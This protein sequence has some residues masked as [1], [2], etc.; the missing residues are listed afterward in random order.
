M[1]DFS[2]PKLLSKDNYAKGG[3]D[4][5]LKSYS[6]VKKWSSNIF[7]GKKGLY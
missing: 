7:I 3:G 5:G 2:K 4:K 1:R 6:V